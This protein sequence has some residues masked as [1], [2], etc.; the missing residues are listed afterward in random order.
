[1][2]HAGDRD[3]VQLERVAERVAGELRHH[4]ADPRRFDLLR[5]DRGIGHRLER[6]VADELLGAR[7]VEL[8]E[9]RA[10]DADDGDFVFEIAWHRDSSIG[11]WPVTRVSAWWLHRTG[12]PAHRRTG[13]P[14]HLTPL[15]TPSG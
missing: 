7:L 9:A 15:I 12:A 14:A 3:A 2:L 1:M 11:D 5:L 6:R 4:R 8:A 13:S 10:A